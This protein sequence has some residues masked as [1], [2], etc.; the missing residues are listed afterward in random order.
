MVFKA[1]TDPLHYPYKVEL[2]YFVFVATVMPMI[3]Q[4]ATQLNSMRGR[5][6]AQK[7][8]WKRLLSEFRSWPPAMN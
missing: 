8:N 2:M 5:L 7:A 4:L 3:S 1:M 6:K